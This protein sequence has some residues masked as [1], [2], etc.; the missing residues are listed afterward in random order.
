MSRPDIVHGY[1]VLENHRA[2]CE[3]WQERLPQ[4]KH[5]PFPGGFEER[6]FVG[7]RLVEIR[8][9]ALGVTVPRPRK[10]LR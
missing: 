5:I 8:R 1:Q 3:W 7:G 2:R 10:L 4:I 9:F 6:T